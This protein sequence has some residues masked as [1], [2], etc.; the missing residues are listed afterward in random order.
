MSTCHS[1]AFTSCST[2]PGNA[3]G[4]QLCF[5]LSYS[6]ILTQLCHRNSIQNLKGS[7][8]TNKVL[9]EYRMCVLCSPISITQFDLQVIC[10]SAIFVF[11]LN[12]MY[13]LCLSYM[14]GIYE[15]FD[16]TNP[17][18][19]LY[20]C[21]SCNIFRVNRPLYWTVCTKNKINYLT[22]YQSLSAIIIQMHK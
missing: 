9:I 2:L 17:T 18:L 12:V 10:L 1:S 3:P 14:N 8:K 11:I 19:F 20:I 16:F 5:L 13:F 15:D 4:L 6:K 21:L 7:N 22:Q